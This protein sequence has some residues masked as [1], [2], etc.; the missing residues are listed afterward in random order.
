VAYFIA[1]IDRGSKGQFGCAGR[2]KKVNLFS[3]VK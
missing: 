2:V 3:L 1:A